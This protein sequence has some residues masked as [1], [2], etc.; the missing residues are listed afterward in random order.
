MDATSPLPGPS[1]AQRWTG[2]VLSTLPVLFLLF[3]SIM[4]L[5]KVPMVLEASA[6]LGFSA[7]AVFTIGAILLIC[8]IAYVIPQTSILGAILLTGYLG[9]A[10]C[11]NLR[12]GNPLFGY[13]LF[14]TYMGILVWLGLYL[15]EP[16]LRAL[17]PLRN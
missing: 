7:S 4:K 1:K 6:K 5:L 10:V 17:V 15:R 12:A 2:Y 16:R 8:V 9:G 13:I 14:P 11:T 3:D